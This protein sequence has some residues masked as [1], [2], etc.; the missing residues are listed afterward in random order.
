MITGTSQADFAILVIDAS[1][2]GFES[3]FNNGGQTKEHLLLSKNLG[4]KIIYIL[5][6]KKVNILKIIYILKKK[7]E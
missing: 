4:K 1:I 3:G 6:K 5:K 7:K 2:G